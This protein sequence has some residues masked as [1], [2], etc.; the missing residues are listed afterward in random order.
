MPAAPNINRRRFL[1][2]AS[3]GVL[4]AACPSLF[5]G[6]GD[7]RYRHIVPSNRRMRIAAIGLGGKGVEDVLSCAALGEEIA[8]LCD[9]DL[10]M[11]AQ[12]FHEFPDAPRYRDF[13]QMFAEMA[14]RIDGVLVS[15]P[16]H[17]HFP[18]TMLALQLGKHV[19]VQKPLT[20]TIGEAREL[21]KA[22]ARAGVVTQMGNQGHANEGTRLVREWIEAGAIG[23]VRE[24]HSWTNRPV[25][26]QGMAWPGAAPAVPA[27]MDWNLWLGVAPERPYSPEIAPFNWR[28]FWDYG[29]GALGDMG[30]HIM[31]APFWA[32]N[33][34][35]P[36]RVSAA[37]EG[38]SEV[39]APRWSI[40]TYEFP[41]RGPLPPL[42]YVWYDGGKRPPVPEEL[43]PGAKLPKGGTIYRGDKGVLLAQGDY[44]ESVRLI[45]ESAMRAFKRPPKSIPRI[46]QSNP[47]LEWIAACRDGPAP[48]SNIV[49][50]AADLTEF[51]SLGNIA[52]RTGRSINWDPIDGACVGLP[53]ADRFIHKSYR[54][55]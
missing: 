32:L 42:K 37:S 55:Y 54:I 7:S 24:V 50:H 49:D 34:R 20:H 12:L 18:A 9:P 51:V 28:G 1:Q 25:W 15:T 46:P 43:G 48:G 5:A 38:C 4:A 52:L 40:V 21:K 6:I 31:D 33:L 41:A 39:A 16:D 35:G 23:S 11:A 27:T 45:P 17:A 47:Y 2:T 22:A 36:V 19:Y 10:A 30:C 26:P 14:D 29:C 8:A 44:S 53:E 13:R 3:L